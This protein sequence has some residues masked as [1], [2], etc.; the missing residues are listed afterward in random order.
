[1]MHQSLTALIGLLE[2]EETIYREMAVLLD[3]EREALLGMAVERLGE[4]TARKETLVLRIKALDESR[5]LL[6]RRLGDACGL[7]PEEVTISRLCLIAPPETAARLSRIGQALR[8]TLERC[9][10]VN[11][12]NERAAS[13]G[14]SLIGGAIEYLIAQADPLGK[15]YQAPRA[16]GYGPALRHGA[17]GFISRQV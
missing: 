6:A 1:M 7:K 15:L 8:A 13:R 10:A 11:T 12:F 16:K 5:K 3:E 17:S 14:M 2:Q 9:Q 4:I